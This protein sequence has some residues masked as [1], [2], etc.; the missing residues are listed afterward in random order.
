MR[1]LSLGLSA[2]CLVLTAS[3]GVHAEPRTGAG[4][5]KE[6]KAARARAADKSNTPP[7]P[8]A[9]AAPA[10]EP[11]NGDRLPP[12][13]AG[14]VF[15]LLPS[16]SGKPGSSAA[17]ADDVGRAITEHLKNKGFKVLPASQVHSQLSSHA[18]EG[19]KNPTTC[20]PA[21]ALATLGADAVISI[22]VWARKAAPP[23]IVVYVRRQHGYGQAEVSARGAQTKEL[24]TAGLSALQTALED[25]QRTHEIDVVIES[26]PIGATVH[27]DQSLSGTTPAHFA[28][29]PGSHLVSV[30]APGFVT[31]AQYL[32]L[33]D[34]SPQKKLHVKLTAAEAETA[35]AAAGGKRRA[36]L[37]ARDKPQPERA[38][39]EAEA[40]PAEPPASREAYTSAS[41]SPQRDRAS[42]MNYVVA[43][44]LLGVAAPFI[45]NAIYAG[46][47]RGQCVGPVDV[48][49]RC[50]ERVGLGP[51]F[52]ASVGVGAA[53]ALTGAT[54]LVVQPLT[55][56]G[57]VPQGARLQ[58]TQRF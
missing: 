28:L 2:L 43:A 3:A 32:E 7:E 17:G 42:G 18:L 25:S 37:E 48:A 5:K 33:S 57:P 14:S 31:S 49:G 13:S 29:L 35:K 23:Q 46:A 50:S 54:F 16:G 1:G 9:P 19:C 6:A 36:D 34:Q 41:A 10:P 27:V 55:E 12:L 51:A 47:T 40:A 8:P 20:D 30:E 39:L 52:F 11:G 56:A 24:R 22:A 53:A 15:A 4:A 58:L 26:L 44:V 45:A 21:L 38:P